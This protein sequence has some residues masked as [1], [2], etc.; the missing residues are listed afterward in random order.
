MNLYYLVISSNPETY[1]MKIPIP[2]LLFF[3]LVFPSLMTG[4]MCLPEGIHFTRQSQIDSF[5]ILYPGCTQIGGDVCIGN[6]LD[7]VV[8]D[9]T[10]LDGLESLTSINGKLTISHNPLL[11]SIEGLKNLTVLEDDV[12]LIWNLNLPSLLY[13]SL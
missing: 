13:N 1:C 5:S 7:L 10:N 6:C 4:Q 11:T 8:S 3:M 12:K 2:S 9:I